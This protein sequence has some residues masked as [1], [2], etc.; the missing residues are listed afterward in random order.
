MSTYSC[1]KHSGYKIYGRQIYNQIDVE[2]IRPDV[3][4]SIKRLKNCNLL[5]DV[6]H[7][8]KITIHLVRAIKLTMEI[9]RDRRISVVSGGEVY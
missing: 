8:A 9:S 5:V 3:T 1:Q 7:L 4:F 2:A 6:A